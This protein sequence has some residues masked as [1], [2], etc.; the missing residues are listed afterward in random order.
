MFSLS[1]PLQ[2]LGVPDTDERDGQRGKRQLNGCVMKKE[3]KSIDNL[4]IADRKSK[5]AR[6]TVAPVSFTSGFNWQAGEKS[7]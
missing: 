6:K 4:Q 2:R 7:A 3:K 5:R 1:Q